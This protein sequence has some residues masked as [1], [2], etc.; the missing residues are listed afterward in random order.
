M[1]TSFRCKLKTQSHRPQKIMIKHILTTH[2]FSFF[3]LFLPLL[4]L[5]SLLQAVVLSQL[6]PL[7]RIGHQVE[8]DTEGGIHCLRMPWIQQR[9]HQTVDLMSEQEVANGMGPRE[10]AIN[11]DALSKEVKIV[12]VDDCQKALTKEKRK[13]I[14]NLIQIVLN[15]FM[16]FNSHRWSKKASDS[17]G[18]SGTSR[19]EKAQSKK[20][21]ISFVVSTAKIY[22]TFRRIQS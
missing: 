17:W 2:S 5:C 21:T 18:N 22:F 20:R 14:K 1:I 7:L 16:Y 11:T 15:C 19:R 6:R 12:D 8:K 10:V 4:L 3:P 9:N 13:K